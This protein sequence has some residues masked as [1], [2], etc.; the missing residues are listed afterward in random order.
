M[1]LHE[2]LH[3]KGNN[4]KV[5]LENLTLLWP[6]KPLQ[7]RSGKGAEHQQSD[8]TDENVIDLIKMYL[9]DYTLERINFIYADVFETLPDYPV[10]LQKELTSNKIILSIGN[11]LS[12]TDKVYPN[13]SRNYTT[14]KNRLI[15]HRCLCSKQGLKKEFLLKHKL[16]DRWIL[17]GSTCIIKFAERYKAIAEMS[18][19]YHRLMNYQMAQDKFI[20]EKFP[21]FQ[22]RDWKGKDVLIDLTIYIITTKHLSDIYN[23]FPI[24]TFD[25][26]KRYYHRYII[27]EI[28]SLSRRTTERIR[29]EKVYMVV[30]QMLSKGN[31][32]R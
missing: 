22:N 31:L 26:A 1:K 30:K 24:F 27:P 10:E 9:E 11:C 25:K 21:D 18:E 32:S 29:K 14:K 17:L 16:F 15:N 5:L 23:R 2:Y 19:K 28:N 8:E 20:Q 7:P 4:K 12:E 3:T 6:F 13:H